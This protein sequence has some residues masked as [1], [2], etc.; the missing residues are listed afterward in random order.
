VSVSAVV[1]GAIVTPG[2]VVRSDLIIEDGKVAAI[3]PCPPGAVA[4]FAATGCYVLPGGV[5]PHT[6]LMSAPSLAA[7]A[8]ARGGTTTAISFTSPRPGESDLECLLRSRDELTDRQIAIDIGLHAALYDPD[9][10]SAADLA[11]ARRAGAAAVKVFLAYPELEI[12]CSDA[13]LAELMSLT[14]RLGMVIAVHCENARLIADREAQAAA[15]AAAGSGPRTFAGTRPPEAEDEAVGRVLAAASDT[16]ATCYL[17]HLSTAGAL[18]HVRQ[19]RESG[20]AGVHAEV[21][22]HHLLLDSAHYDRPDGGRYL[23]CPPLRSG[24]DVEALWAGLADGTISAVGSDHCQAKTPTGAW[25]TG[26]QLAYGLAGIGP[27]LPLL[28][29]EATARGLTIAQVARLAAENP[30]RAFG[31]YPRKGALLPGSDADVVIFD[32]AGESV[33]PAD[34][35]GD[36]T[37]DSVYAGLAMQ[38]RIR[39]VL[40]RGRLIVA[41][42]EPVGHDPG[43]TFL[44]A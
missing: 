34:G 31:H 3:G 10:F 43:G 20:R 16:G 1:G 26:R 18:R 19:A 7:A 25:L 24:G 38:G 21:C 30:A 6:H 29:S 9:Q 44:A 42:D 15:G 33:V 4:R 37:G 5:D 17:V 11:A 41:E 28:L 27:R 39:S 23:V 22:L 8:A 36:G 13:R 14:R 2:G 12:M 35:F 40:L 32:P